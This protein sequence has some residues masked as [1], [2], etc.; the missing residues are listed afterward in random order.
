MPAAFD[1]FIVF[2]EMRTG[3]NFL[4]A[5]LNA[6]P[7][8]TSYGEAFNPHFIGGPKY[9]DIL[10]ISQE[11]RDRDPLSLI[12][13][14]RDVPG[15]LGGFRYFHDHDPR[16]LEHALSDPRCAK[17]I[18]TRNPLD[19]YV[20]WKIARAT[21]QWQL[22]NIKR[23]KEAKAK[24][25]GQ[26]FLD[27]VETI[28]SFQVTLLNALQKTGQTAFY[29]DYEDLQDVEVLNGLA[30]WLGVKGRLKE[31]DQSLVRQNP[32]PVEAKV[33]NP[34]GMAKALAKLDRFNLTRTPNFE[35]RR[36]PTVPNYVLGAETPLMFMPVAGGPDGLVRHWMAALD[37]V[38]EGNLTSGANQKAIRRWMR[39]RPEHR[40]FTLVCHPLA[41]AH[42]VFCRKI[43]ATEQGSY[44][45]IRR[46]LRD[47]YK[48]PL[49]QEAP[50]DRYTKEDHRAAFEA[51][52]GFLRLNL[53]GQTSIRVDGSWGSQT[54]TLAGFASFALPDMVLRED[55]IQA[56]L[57]ALARQ[58]GHPDPPALLTRT[59][60]EPYALADIYDADLEKTCANTYQRDY[61]QF[62]FTNWRAP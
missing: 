24:F 32:D 27:H 44:L 31:L 26:E 28:Q 59:A 57:P 56:Q 30:A 62:G 52:L 58:L 11:A 23:R 8:I 15:T 38:S 3:S 18:L 19:S 47:H 51:F 20:S 54:E 25:D 13:A 45:R 10:N 4:E 12:A 55:D 46:I 1:Y 7:G 9:S 50:D 34:K 2:A 33:S 41:R 39:D 48:L 37:D 61:I 6:L 22:T 21:K 36:G 29:L 42:T 53:A 16:I 5:N 40:R 43:L 14:I 17:I 49:P 35:P 60:D